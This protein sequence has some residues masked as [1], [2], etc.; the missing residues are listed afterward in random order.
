VEAVPAGLADFCESIYPTLVGVLTVHVGDREVARE[1]AQDT[2]VRVCEHWPRVATMDAPKAWAYRVAFNLATSRF[3]RGAAERRALTRVGA[4]PEQHVEPWNPE[5]MAL[6]EALVTLP[7]RQ[8][9]VLGLRF[10]ADLPVEEVAEIMRCAP[11]TVKSMT[12]HAV[13]ALRRKTTGLRLEQFEG[14]DHD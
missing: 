8:R 2:M 6:R 9:Q 3:R 11:G 13:E 5:V 1:L 7:P 10:F 12:S 4:R 14:A